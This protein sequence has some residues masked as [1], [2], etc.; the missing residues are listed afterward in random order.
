MGRKKAKSGTWVTREMLFSRAYWA[1]NPPAS[2]MLLLF[3]LK[4]DMDK[5]HNL[6]NG[7]SIT[8]TYLELENMFVANLGRKIAGIEPRTISGQPTGMSKASIARGFH[9]LLAKGFVEIVKQ[10]GAYRKDKTIYG[11]TED[12]QWW[13]EG[14]IIREKSKGKKVART[15][16]ENNFQSS[17]D[18][19]ALLNNDTTQ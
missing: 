14:A 7:K 12:W 18:T 5:K 2:K 16:H 15:N 19:R 10:G 6:L 8:M 3:L 9:D 13:T 11:L 1:L 4:R 17:S